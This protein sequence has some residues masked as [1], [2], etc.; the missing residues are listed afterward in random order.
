MVR[1]KTI[2]RCWFDVV[3]CLLFEEKENVMMILMCWFFVRVY[4]Y[5]LMMMVVVMIGESQHTV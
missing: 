3:D 2:F 1:R 4:L 5:I